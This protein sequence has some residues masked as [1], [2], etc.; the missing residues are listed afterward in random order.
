MVTIVTQCRFDHLGTAVFL[1]AA[2]AIGHATP[3]LAQW[4]ITLV[5]DEVSTGIAIEGGESPSIFGQEIAFFGDGN[6]KLFKAGPGGVPVAVFQ[7]GVQIPMEPAGTNFFQIFE[8]YS[9]SGQTFAFRGSTTTPSQNGSY[10]QTNSGLVALAGLGFMNPGSGLPNSAGAFL[11]MDGNDVA[12]GGTTAIRVRR[13]S[14]VVQ[15]IADNTTPVPGAPGNNFSSFSAMDF[16]NGT[17]VFT[18][19]SLGASGFRTGIYYEI[20]TGIIFKLVDTTTVAPGGV[21]SAPFSAFA[22]SNGRF[23]LHGNDVVFYATVADGRTGIFISRNF[24]APQIIADYDPANPTVILPPFTERAD[25]VQGISVSNGEVAFLARSP[26]NITGA[27]FATHGGVIERVIGTGAILNGR[28][29]DVPYGLNEMRTGSTIAF[30]V[31]FVENFLQRGIYRADRCGTLQSQIDAALPGSTIYAFGACNEN[32]LVRNEKQRIT[33]QGVGAGG[34]GSRATIIGGAGAPVFNVRGKGILIQ[35]LNI[36]GGSHGVHVNRGS[37]AV[38]N[39]NVIEL[40]NG[41]GVIV[42]ELAYAVLTN[43]RIQNNPGAGV[44]VSEN[45]SARIGFNS[46]SET[47]GSLNF[48]DDNTLGVVISNNSN[49]RIHGNQ[50]QGNSGAGVL[51]M[52]DSHAD[53]GSND[54]FLNGDGIEVR[55]NSSVQLGED[56]GTGF[57]ERG[58]AG[59]TNTGF[60]IKCSNGGTADGRIQN[61]TGGSGAKDFSDPT[62]I[63]SLL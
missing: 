4:P 58:N 30:G 32:V 49:A 25:M 59:T 27:I 28:T 41:N 33:I 16:H 1:G 61:L 26:G 12:F 35:D 24:G 11:A 23:A 7:T 18:G 47:A 48:I 17:V 54:F 6:T 19:S 50:I 63:D 20:G 9:F 42:D 15:L 2:L 52:R 57:Y 39:N 43:N 56:T 51:V 31:L 44:L 13:S 53:I 36:Q 22:T 3:A 14:G 40:T 60:G 34:P 46:D 21:A 45:S 37:N 55:E 8:P 10:A 29:V 62:C 38:L 5:A